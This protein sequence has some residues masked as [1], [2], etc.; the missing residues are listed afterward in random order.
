MEA[1]GRIMPEVS[2]A[3]GVYTA[4]RLLDRGIELF[5]DTRVTSMVGGHVKLDDGTEFDTDTIVWTAGVRANPLVQRTDL[6]LDDKK[7]VRCTA[8][9]QVQDHPDAF[10]AGDSAAVPDLTP[11]AVVGPPE[12]CARGLR[13]II[14]AGAERVLLNP[15]FDEAEQ[16]ER[17]VA[18]VV[19]LLSS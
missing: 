6:P 19:P 9:L 15:M 2:R 3:M 7:R 12:A 13:E 1:T 8:T 16:M 14:D 4:Q 10:C 11:V 17:L 18:E 5:L